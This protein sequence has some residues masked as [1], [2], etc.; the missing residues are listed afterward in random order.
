MV[1]L[2]L[3]GVVKTSAN[4]ASLHVVNAAECGSHLVHVRVEFGELCELPQGLLDE[5][6]F[7]LLARLILRESPVSM[8]RK[9][10]DNMADI[11]P[12]PEFISRVQFA[13]RIHRRFYDRAEDTCVEETGALHLA[14]M[15]NPG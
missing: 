9:L 4:V 6:I 7:S 12:R 10:K 3:E 1:T 15:E 5:G 8:V 11:A 2:H 14:D 13:V